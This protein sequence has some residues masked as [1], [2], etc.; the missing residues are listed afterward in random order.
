MTQ[1]LPSMLISYI[2]YITEERIR[3]LCSIP[4]HLCKVYPRISRTRENDAYDYQLI[5]IV[6]Y[7]SLAGT[8][9]ARNDTTIEFPVS[10]LDIYS[11]D[12][13]S[14]M[15]SSEKRSVN[16]RYSDCILISSSFSLLGSSSL[17]VSSLQSA[18]QLNLMKYVYRSS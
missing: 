12:Q 17:L 15:L 18:V 8:K 6:V 16:P 3:L 9:S 11:S 13:R 14:P 1:T 4:I 7:T 2:R 10:R 5:C